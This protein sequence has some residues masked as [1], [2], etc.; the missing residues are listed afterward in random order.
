MKPAVVLSII[1][2][3]LAGCQSA[4]R[5]GEPNLSSPWYT[6]PTGST[7]EILQPLSVP[8][9]SD[10]VYFQEGRRLPWQA[11]N[12]Y[13]AYC[14]L[15]LADR[16][17]Q[18]RTIAPDDYNVR[19]VSTRRLFQLAGGL[20]AQPIRVAS[21]GTDDSRND[22]E[23]LALVMK[24]DGPNTQVEALACADWVIPQGIRSVT[25]ETIRASLGAAIELRL[26]DR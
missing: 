4:Y 21:F 8:A 2:T 17:D 5:N 25:V 13:R 19:A 20:P 23:V 3:L 18:A 22:Y 10:R 11:V 12:E 9:R 6:P 24:L 1:A 26:A 16:S 15:M 7:L 14:A